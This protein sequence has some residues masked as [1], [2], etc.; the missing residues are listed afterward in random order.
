MLH[1][2]GALCRRF[3]PG[4]LILTGL[5][6]GFAGLARALDIPPQPS[7]RISDYASVLDPATKDRLENQLEQF[8]KDTS[9]QIVVATFP[10][11]EDEDVDDFTNRLFAAWK[12]GQKQRN[13]GVLLAIFM[14]QKKVRIEVGYGLEGAL[15]DATSAQIIRNELAPEFRAGNPAAGIEKAIVAIEKATRGEYKALPA[16]RPGSGW[17]TLA[18]IIILIVFFIIMSRMSRGGV[19]LP[20][21]PGGRRRNRDDGWWSGGGFGGGGF[22][23]GGFGGG[24]GGGGFSGG[25]GMSGG[26][27]AS[28]GW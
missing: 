2:F 14:Q 8:E 19:F 10:S 15:T 11:L 9:N 16:K 5:L 3:I 20:G 6:L 25:G 12:I 24:G 28:G 21:I 4:L 18:F 13:N 1:S 17:S 27:G 23:G 7:G 22:G 26:G